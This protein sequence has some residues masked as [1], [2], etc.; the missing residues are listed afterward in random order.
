MA[1]LQ[2]TY[3]LIFTRDSGVL[4]SLL[5]HCQGA[6][7][8]LLAVSDSYAG[9]YRWWCIGTRCPAVQTEV[10]ALVGNA[11]NPSAHTTTNANEEGIEIN[12]KM[13]QGYPIYKIDAPVD[14]YYYSGKVNVSIPLGTSKT[15]KPTAA[16]VEN[17]L[18]NIT[19]LFKD[20]PEFSD[21]LITGTGGD[22][23]G[24][25]KAGFGIK[26]IHYVEKAGVVHPNKPYDAVIGAKLR[27]YAR[28]K[29]VLRIK[30][31]MAGLAYAN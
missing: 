5:L 29:N 20:I 8:V 23:S 3:L 17:T 1:A 19:L 30:S 18:S 27:V 21:P 31:G 11:D 15:H 14:G 28:S 13:F 25:I 24:A 10:D 22:T 26:G 6:Q 12:K 16:A 7:K 9:V 4:H 2:Q